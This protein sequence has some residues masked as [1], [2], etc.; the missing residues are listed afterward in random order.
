MTNINGTATKRLIEA[1]VRETRTAKITELGELLGCDPNSSTQNKHQRFRIFL[2]SLVQSLDYLEQV[3]E[4][5]GVPASDL[6]YPENHRRKPEFEQAVFEKLK[7]IDLRLETM[8][9]SGQS[10]KVARA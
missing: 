8:Q 10:K 1:L 3:A 6:L 2:N 7:E 9:A 5:L 4:Y